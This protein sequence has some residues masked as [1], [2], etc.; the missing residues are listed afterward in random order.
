[1]TLITL[2]TQ[3]TLISLNNLENNKPHYN[4]PNYPTPPPPNKQVYDALPFQIQLKDERGDR[5]ERGETFHDY[6][7]TVANNV[8]VPFNEVEANEQKFRSLCAS[9]PG[10]RFEPFDPPLTRA[11]VL[12]NLTSPPIGAGG[13]C[14]NS[15]NSKESP[16]FAPACLG[17]AIVIAAKEVVQIAMLVFVRWKNRAPNGTR[18]VVNSCILFPILMPKCGRRVT[19][20]KLLRDAETWHDAVM[21][22]IFEGLLENVPQLVLNLYYMTN[23]ARTGL[24]TLQVCVLC[25]LPSEKQTLVMPPTLTTLDKN[26]MSILPKT[27]ITLDKKTLV[28]ILLKALINCN[29]NEP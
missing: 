29:H 7:R 3:T 1:M 2:V 20:V 25:S 15:G 6:M 21:E 9:A 13:N 19:Y 8:V 27:L 17:L 18:T 28:F 23:V 11:A 24:S 5:I 12:S 16:L 22:F 26:L 10:C 14:E 4:N